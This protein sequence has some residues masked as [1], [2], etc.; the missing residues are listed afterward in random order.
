MDM[1]DSFPDALDASP[2]LMCVTSPIKTTLVPLFP[3][4]VAWP[5]QSLQPGRPQ[6]KPKPPP[7]ATEPMLQVLH[8]VHAHA[9]SEKAQSRSL[10]GLWKVKVKRRRQGSLMMRL[11][12]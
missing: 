5:L 2:E 11:Q 8:V 3:V 4:S 7:S 1:G 6:M 10:V 12:L 9:P